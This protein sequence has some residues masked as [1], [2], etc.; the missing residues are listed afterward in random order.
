MVLFFFHYD[1]MFIIFLGA[2]LN[3]KA[4]KNTLIYS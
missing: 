3:N 2:M 4:K 1:K